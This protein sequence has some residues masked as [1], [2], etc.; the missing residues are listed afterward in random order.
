[1]AVLGMAVL[2]MAELD[3]RGNVNLSLFG[4]GEKRLVD[5]RLTV[6]EI[7]PGV[8]LMRDVLE[9]CGAPVAVA[10]HLELMDERILRDAPMPGE[11]AALRAASRSP[12]ATLASV[13]N[14]RTSSSSPHPRSARRK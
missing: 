12:G 13:A 5:R 1:M 11:S 8:D 14:S 3:V 2:G 9:R 6:V 10:P 7:A 4:E